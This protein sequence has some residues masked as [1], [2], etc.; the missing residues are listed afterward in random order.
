MEA[1][2]GIGAL[3]SRDESLSEQ[4]K[5]WL[6][7]LNDTGLAMKELFSERALLFLETKHFANTYPAN[8]SPAP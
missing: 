6:Q 4:Q 1:I 5:R 8:L 3:M 7:T 2:V